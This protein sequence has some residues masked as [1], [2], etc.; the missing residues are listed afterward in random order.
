[1]AAN[2]VPL[3]SPDDWDA[4][5]NSAFPAFFESIMVPN[6]TWVGGDDVMVPPELSAMIPEQ[7]DWIGSASIFD[8]DF[9]L[10]IDKAMDPLPAA[11]SVHTN[12]VVNGK[13]QQ[14]SMKPN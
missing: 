4:A 14:R 9:S 10:A 6:Q 12:E 13:E 2:T 5:F 7:E 11:V 1:M 3:A 8:V